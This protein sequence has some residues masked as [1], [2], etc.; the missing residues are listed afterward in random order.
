VPVVVRV[1]W[2][3]RG[4][5][6]LPGDLGWLAPGELRRARDLRYPKRHTEY[7]LRRLA[8]KHAVAAVTG[9]PADP[10]ALARIE[11]ANAPGG[12]PYVLVDGA[13]AA[14]SVSIS[15]RAGWAV[16]LIA[17]IDGAGGRGGAGALG[18][19]LELVEPRSPQFLQDFLTPEERDY[20]AAAPEGDAR[21]VAANLIW[22]AKESA[23]KV[24]RTGLRRDTREVCV[25]VP[26]PGPGEWSGLRIRARGRPVTGW[27][28]RDGSFLVTVASPAPVPAPE[29]LGDPRA[30][31]AAAPVH[32]WLERPAPR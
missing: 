30:L 12:A 1:H 13:P 22:S 18:C 16:C 8:A 26:A 17:A 24:L 7:L 20:V 28:R 5:Q 14:L 25:T 21:Q 27:W 6:A 23:L 4:E 11:V 15:D 9:L 32:S 19:D 29:A 2:L 10:A 3:V 31:A